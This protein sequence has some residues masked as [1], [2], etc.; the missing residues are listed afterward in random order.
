MNKLTLSTATLALAAIFASSAFAAVD[1][2]GR[3]IQPGT[4]MIYAKPVNVTS[5]G[6]TQGTGRGATVEWK[7]FAKSNR[8]VTNAGRN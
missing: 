3:S 6:R 2:T 8:N 1:V 5:D 4:A 7:Q